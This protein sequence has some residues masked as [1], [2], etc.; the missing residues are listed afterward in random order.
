MVDAGGPQCLHGDLCLLVVPRR[1]DPQEY[2]T[3]R[4]VRAGQVGPGFAGRGIQA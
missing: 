4:G 2:L 1:S 3:A